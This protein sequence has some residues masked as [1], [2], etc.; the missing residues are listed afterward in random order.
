MPTEITRNDIEKIVP[1]LK[2]AFQKSHDLTAQDLWG[3]LRENSPQDHGYLAGSWALQRGGYMQSTVGTHVDYALV[4]DQGSDPYEIFPRVG[5]A[6]R[7]EISG[8]VIFAKSVLHPGI[9]G[10]NYVEG[11]IA[12]TESRIGEFVEMALDAEGL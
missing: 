8:Q 9:A 1:Q 10:T 2:S 6:L 7:F 5:K 3:N 12:Q 4:Q 11:S